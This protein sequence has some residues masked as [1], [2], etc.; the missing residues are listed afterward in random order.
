MD[1]IKNLEELTEPLRNPVLT[2]G[3]FDG[4]HRGHLALFNKVKERAAAIGGQ[5]A[6]MTFEPHPLKILDPEKSP[7]LITTTRQKIE[8][9][10]KTGMDVL[11]C[12]PFTHE[13]AAIS[14]ES[15]VRDLLLG[16]IGLKEIVVGYDYS[17]GQGRRGNIRLLEDMGES[18]G[19]KVHVVKPVLIQDTPVSSTSIR[20]LLKEGR[21]EEAREF[22]GRAY[23]VAGTVVKGAG[24]GGPILGIPTA[25]L[26]LEEELTP[27]E[28]VY[29]VTVLIDGKTHY[30]VTNIG[31]NPTFG[32][33]TLS[34]ETHIL[35]FTGDLLG[36]T[37]KVNFL[38]RLRDEKTFESVEKLADQITADIRRA[39][40]LF[41]IDLSSQQVAQSR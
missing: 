11:F 18:L 27:R 20:N 29:A 19:F 34:V 2:I 22:L 5:S 8:L 26:V 17:F 38:H 14:A 36:K 31:Y 10:E 25:N 39:R 23:Q 6:V 33:N 21:L 32:N 37:I 1:V 16:K 9:I 30:G 15:F 12:L 35:D 40:H 7:S 3:N 41:G 13:F 24:R 4:V 28:G